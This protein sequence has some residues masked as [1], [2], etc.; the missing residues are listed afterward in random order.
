MIGDLC[1][2]LRAQNFSTTVN[3]QVVAIT[4]V[5][6]RN[7]NEKAKEP[8]LVVQRMG[9]DRNETL[10]GNDDSLIFTDVSIQVHSS[11]AAIDVP[12]AES[13]MQFLETNQYIPMGTRTLF[14]ATCDEPTDI[15]DPPPDASNEWVG[16]T[17]ITAHLEHN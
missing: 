1:T 5:Y 4:K 3:G 12:I 17:Q 15:S 8:Y 11:Q 13:V 2:L 16:G 7:A 14:G 10:D 6:A 9:G